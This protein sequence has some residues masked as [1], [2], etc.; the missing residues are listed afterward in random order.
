MDKTYMEIN[1]IML[2]KADMREYI[3]SLEGN[4]FLNKIITTQCTR[5]NIDEFDQV[6]LKDI[7]SKV[8][9]SSEL[10]VIFLHV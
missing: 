9:D 10:K 1:A 6:K 5:Q 8:N 2:T 4:N 3:G 7:T